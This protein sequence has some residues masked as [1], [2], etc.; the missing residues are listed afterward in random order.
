MLEDFEISRYWVVNA[1]TAKSSRVSTWEE[2]C[3]EGREPRLFKNVP[4]PVVMDTSGYSI[5]YYA[6]LTDQP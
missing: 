5:S 2:I 3:S 6:P 1:G 4:L